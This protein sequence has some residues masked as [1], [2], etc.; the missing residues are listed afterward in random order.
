MLTP[1][2][3]FIICFIIFQR[4]PPDKASCSEFEPP[5]AAAAFFS[6]ELFVVLLERYMAFCCYSILEDEESVTIS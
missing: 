2:F 5:T 1:I 6:F 3:L 4:K